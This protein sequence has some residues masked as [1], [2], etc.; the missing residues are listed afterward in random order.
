MAR[1]ARPVPDQVLVLDGGERARRLG[2]LQVRRRQLS[3]V[4]RVMKINADLGQRAVVYSEELPWVASPLRGVDRRMLERDGEEVA[5][6][7]SVV[8]YAPGSSFDAHVHGGGE[9][10][11]VLDG[12]FSDEHGDFG[13]GMYVRN[14]PGSRH[15]PRSGPGCTI[16]VKLRQM[17]PD[18]QQ[19]VRIDTTATPWQP[20][21][22]EGVSVMPLFERGSEKVALWRLAPGTR[23]ARHNHPGGEETFVLD[24]VLE[25]GLGRYPKGAWLRNPPGSAHQ[26]FSAD[27]C[28]LYVKTGHLG[29]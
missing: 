9:E 23:L 12:V 22:A 4:D 24:G 21:P 15:G 1:G 29:G 27:G 16:L 10:F 8:R 26:P 11:F 2:C 17:V 28:L 14:P 5:R 19:H 25:D 6:A 13:P 18:D 7:T 3:R 20:G